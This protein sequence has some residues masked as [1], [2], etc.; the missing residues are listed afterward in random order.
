MQRYIDASK[1]RLPA[2]TAIDPVDLEAY[3]PL[4]AVR[5]AIALTP[6]EDVV[7]VVRCKDCRY[8]RISTDPKTQI[9]IQVCG[10]VG[11]NPVQSSQVSGTDYCNHGERRT[12]NEAVR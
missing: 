1:I 7:K 6:T 10:F 2:E 9:T 8:C 12:E 4:S 11:F 3:V 5:R